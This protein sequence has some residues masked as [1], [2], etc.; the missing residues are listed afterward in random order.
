MVHRILVALLVFLAP[1]A[2]LAQVSNC[3]AI[4]G[5]LPG[6][7]L[8]PVAASPVAADAPYAVA[9]TYL[10][11]SSF[12]ITAPDGTAVVTDYSGIAGPGGPP[13][14]ATMNHA[15]ISHW[16][17]D[18]DPRIPHVLRGWDEGDGAAEHLLEVGQVLVR[19][20]PTDIRRFDG[21]IE[22]DGNS[23]FIFEIA[24]LCIGHLGHLHQL[25]SQA[26][27]A[28]IGRLDIVFVPIDGTY[29]MDQPAM[30]QVVERLRASL[31]IP[32]HWFSQYTLADFV[33][34]TDADGLAIELHGE[35]TLR[36]SLDTLPERPTLLVLPPLG[37]F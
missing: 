30:M 15:H 7:V 31:A 2:V 37:A 1:T 4:A 16:T 12:R 33:A 27:Y 25:P 26:Q 5:R 35:S 22:E 32:M 3:Q 13:D 11:H 20:V 34:L 10:G 18:P 24:G 8:V 17:P 36:V 21:T 9:I 29:T 14:V 28:E 6:A 19:N 23:I